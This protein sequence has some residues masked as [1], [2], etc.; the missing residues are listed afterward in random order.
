M[1]ESENRGP[2][3]SA[4]AGE[5]LALGTPHHASLR[6]HAEQNS[7]QSGDQV[8]QDRARTTHEGDDNQLSQT[9][10]DRK[11][12]NDSE[13]GAPLGATARPEA[14][15]DSLWGRLVSALSIPGSISLWL[16]LDASA[17]K[18]DLSEESIEEL[19]MTTGLDV[20]EI[21]KYRGQFVR[22]FGQQDYLS[23]EQFMNHYANNPLRDRLAICFGFPKA[24]ADTYVADSSGKRNGVLRGQGNARSPGDSEPHDP[25]GAARVSFGSFVKVMATLNSLENRE[26]ILKLAFR[27]HDFDDDGVI[28]KADLVQYFTRVLPSSVEDESERHASNE[29]KINRDGDQTSDGDVELG[30]KGPAGAPS[31]GAL[32][33]RSEAERIAE[34]IFEEMGID[35]TEVHEG[36]ERRPS[37]ISYHDFQ[38]TLGTTDF[39]TRL[40]LNL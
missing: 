20:L 35:P 11:A 5:P 4:A 23:L 13:G 40:R 1:G 16:G 9:P 28:S 29:E 30:S 34:R 36:E 27:I 19:R 37:G 2:A 31:A 18:T 6:R 15:P 7:D 14:E 17:K 12:S 24:K 33:L 39:S 3:A 22:L 38:Y 25:P 26:D 8:R 32:R 21:V 10:N